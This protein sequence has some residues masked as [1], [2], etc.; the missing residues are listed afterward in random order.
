MIHVLSI[1]SHQYLC[2][3]STLFQ[4]QNKRAVEEELTLTCWYRSEIVATIRNESRGWTDTQTIA[5]TEICPART[6]SGVITAYTSVATVRIGCGTTLSGSHCHNR[7]SPTRR[8]NSTRRMHYQI[9]KW[10]WIGSECDR[11]SNYTWCTQSGGAISKWYANR[12]QITQRLNANI[13]YLKEVLL[14]MIS[15]LPA[16]HS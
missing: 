2:N 11:G 9:R 16:A 15:F 14:K 12:I 4:I 3:K 5:T 8:L 10:T 6:Q 13:S 1:E 7:Q